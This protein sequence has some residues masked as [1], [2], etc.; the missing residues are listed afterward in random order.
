MVARTIDPDDPLTPL[1]VA[2]PWSHQRRICYKAEHT[3][4][5]ASLR[6][7]VTNLPGRSR[8]VFS[9]YNDRGEFENRIEEFKTAVLLTI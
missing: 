7:L 3:A 2:P 4:A 5:G 1:A 8:S 6:F 9:F